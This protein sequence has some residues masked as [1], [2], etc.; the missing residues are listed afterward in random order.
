ML[1]RECHLERFLAS[2][3]LYLLQKTEKTWLCCG[4]ALQHLAQGVMNLKWPYVFVEPQFI[5]SF[6]KIKHLLEE[7]KSLLGGK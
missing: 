4:T 3:T 6:C 7:T 1:L 2:P 5:S